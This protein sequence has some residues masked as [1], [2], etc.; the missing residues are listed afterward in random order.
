MDSTEIGVAADMQLGYVVGSQQTSSRNAEFAQWSGPI[1]GVRGEPSL[2]RFRLD[3]ASRYQY[4]SFNGSAD[5]R[6]TAQMFQ[7][8][9]LAG[10]ELGSNDGVEHGP[11]LGIGG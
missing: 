6:P 8:V 2:R 4:M 9:V 3:V 7:L 1:A 5:S 11:R 10:V